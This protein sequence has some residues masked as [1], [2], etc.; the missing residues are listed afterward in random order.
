MGKIIKFYWETQMKIWINV[1]YVYRGKNQYLK[2]FSMSDLVYIKCNF[3]QSSII[4][5]ELH[6]PISIAWPMITKIILEYEKKGIALSD[7]K[8]WYEAIITNTA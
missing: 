4:L 2:E 7:S 3:S 8:I 1:K 5:L 6:K